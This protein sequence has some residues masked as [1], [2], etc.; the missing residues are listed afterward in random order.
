MRALINE[1]LLCHL[2]ELFSPCLIIY[3]YIYSAS[4][5]PSILLHNQ[6]D[7]HRICTR[8]VC[9]CAQ[10]FSRWPASSA[11]KTLFS[12]RDVYALLI[13]IHWK[14]RIPALNISVCLALEYRPHSCILLGEVLAH[15]DELTRVLDQYNRVKSSQAPLPGV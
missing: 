1:V 5:V 7:Q 12:V 2:S 9:R 10:S 13:F 15:N 4:H 8:L 11:I 3:I 14:S 6:L